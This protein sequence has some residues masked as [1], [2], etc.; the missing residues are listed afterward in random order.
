MPLQLEVKLSKV[1]MFG[2][3]LVTEN[4][5]S[6]ELYNNSQT[7]IFNTNVAGLCFDKLDMSEYLDCLNGVSQV[8]IEAVK[9]R[10]QLK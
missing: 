5:S 7:E 6:L 2:F 9:L 1:F 3:A 8:P 10:H 4:L